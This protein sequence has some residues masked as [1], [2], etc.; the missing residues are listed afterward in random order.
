[1]IPSE[2]LRQLGTSQR[3]TGEPAVAESN[4]A[5]DE[6]PRCRP[7]HSQQ[8]LPDAVVWRHGS[9]TISPTAIGRPNVCTFSGRLISK[10][11]NQPL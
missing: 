6:K 7:S 8:H 9:D 1:M 10:R 11:K 3:V 5:D 4:E 2:V